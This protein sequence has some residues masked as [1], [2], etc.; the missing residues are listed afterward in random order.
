MTDDERNR[1]FMTVLLRNA[2]E[3]AVTHALVCACLE[4]LPDAIKALERADGER[5]KALEAGIQAFLDGD[6]ERPVGKEWRSDGKP[7]KHDRCVHDVWMYE[8]CEACV[9]L[10]FQDLLNAARERQGGK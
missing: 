5:I 6:Y 2:P 8:Y 7:S 10:H 1:Q 4:A 9:D 3:G